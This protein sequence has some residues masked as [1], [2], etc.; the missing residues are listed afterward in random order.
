MDKKIITI[1]LIEDDP[2]DNF[3]FSEML[4]KA[5]N[6]STD[7]RLSSVERLAEAFSQLQN[8]NF[9]LIIT[10]LGL[11][12]SQ[13]M[14]TLTTLKQYSKEI[15]VIVLTNLNEETAGIEAVQNGAQDY[16][17]K[18]YLTSFWLAHSIRYAMERSNLQKQIDQIKEE[19]VATITHDLKSPVA[20]I[21]GFADLL[22]NPTYGEISS[23]K[24]HFARIIK[25]ASELLLGLINN[26]LSAS[27]IEAGKMTYTF[28][29]FNLSELMHE[30][31][32]VFEPQFL[33]KGIECQSICPEDI[34]VHADRFW[35][36]QV[37]YNLL[38]NAIKFTPQGGKITLQ[39]VPGNDKVDIEVKDT[40][41]GIPESERGKLFQKYSQVQG[42][43]RG[44]GL[45]LYIV[46]HILV[47]HNSQVSME[48]EV[49]KGSTFYFSLPMEKCSEKI[50]VPG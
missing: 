45:G 44:T 26:I 49:G 35:L 5:R 30:I 33:Q 41:Q 17:V 46:K 29:Y 27:K 48:S 19:F 9:D 42:D 34:C 3:L 40:G 37:F 14:E 43:R 20:S 12:D 28:T 36:R 13:G 2:D 24:M 6:K 32:E 1:L 7:Y 22:T 50:E 47:G 38:S 16:L 8:Q 21:I 10:D 39:A 15:P 31:I 18:G 25:H 11:P 4:D 23:R